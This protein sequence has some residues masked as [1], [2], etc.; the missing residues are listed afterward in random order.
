MVYQEGQ[1]IYF[2]GFYI[3]FGQMRSHPE[4]IVVSKC[5]Q[6][7]PK[8]NIATIFGTGYLPGRWRSPVDRVGE[9][10]RTMCSSGSLVSPTSIY[11]I[12]TR[13]NKRW[14]CVRSLFWILSDYS[15]RV[16]RQRSCWNRPKRGTAGS[17]KNRLRVVTASKKEPLQAGLSHRG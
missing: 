7:W 9:A 17:F 2:D 4:S 10:P 3:R 16:S 11:R 12:D 13:Y 15:T 14:L 1:P 8:S 6:M 5:G